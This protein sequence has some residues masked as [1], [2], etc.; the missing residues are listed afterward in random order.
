MEDLAASWMRDNIGR[1]LVT[2]ALSLGVLTCRTTK[3]EPR[4]FEIEQQASS[5]QLE[6]RMQRRQKL[7]A[8]DSHKRNS[9]SGIRPGWGTCIHQHVS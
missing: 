8:V 6:I 2:W 3:P 5:L 9:A 4:T 7:S 1:L